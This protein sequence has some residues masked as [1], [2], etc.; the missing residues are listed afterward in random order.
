M[1]NLGGLPGSLALPGA[2]GEMS[3]YWAEGSLGR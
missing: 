3:C 1:L 2:L